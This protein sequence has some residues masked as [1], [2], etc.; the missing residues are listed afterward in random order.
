MNLQEKG[1]RIGWLDRVKGI[2]ILF[3]IFAHAYTGE[4]FFFPRMARSLC[5]PL[6]FI[7]SG[8]LIGM[9]REWE[10]GSKELIRKKLSS[11]L[12]PYFIY[13]GVLMAWLPIRLFLFGHGSLYEIFHCLADV[14][15]LEGIGVLWFLSALFIGE[16]LLLFSMKWAGI[17]GRASSAQNQAKRLALLLIL[18]FLCACLMIRFTQQTAGASA[19]LKLIL[20][21]SRI[22]ARG[23][24]AAGMM[25][26]G[27]LINR[28]LQGFP[29]A[30][31]SRFSLLACLPLAAGLWHNGPCDFHYLSFGCF[32]LYILNG[33]LGFT[34][35]A[36]VSRL[37]AKDRILTFLGRNSLILMGTHLVFLDFISIM[38]L[39]LSVR[40]GIYLGDSLWGKLAALLAME[41][42]LFR[43][44]GRFHTPIAPAG[45]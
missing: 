6:F 34:V 22:L 4:D 13:S 17:S 33:I 19:L 12:R 1:T 40:T 18:F 24:M 44:R 30:A 7:A 29:S 37:P 28:C 16:L 8:F 9:K 42:L 20:K 38:A 15:F 21:L 11:I 26:A 23:T 41:L 10:Q 2:G 3:V 43:I 14:F 39:R 45:K 35:I 31:L 5:M 36:A 27:A 25:A 32:P